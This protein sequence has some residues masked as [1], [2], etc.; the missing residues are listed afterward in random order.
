MADSKY[1]VMTLT[2]NHSWRN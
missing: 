1:F 2:N